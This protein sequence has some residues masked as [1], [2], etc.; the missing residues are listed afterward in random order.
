MKK[1]MFSILL[2]IFLFSIG[3]IY[4]LRFSD[5]SRKA[6]RNVAN[7]EKLK[8]GMNLKEL[9]IIMG[10]PDTLYPAYSNYKQT[11][12][13]YEPPF[14]SSAGIE[15]YIDSTMKIDKVIPFEQWIYANI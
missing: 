4:F 5:R 7:S 3:G 13:Y 1:I 6:Y 11:I 8:I 9:T 12:Y 15:V 2:F 10:Q 14:A